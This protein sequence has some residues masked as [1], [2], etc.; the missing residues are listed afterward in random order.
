MKIYIICLGILIVIYNLCISKRSVHM[1]QQNMYNENNRY[2]K[3]VFKNL[4]ETFR[5]DILAL[6]FVV[7]VLDYLIE[8]WKNS[9]KNKS[10]IVLIVLVYPFSLSSTY[11]HLHFN[12]TILIL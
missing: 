5:F 6:I 12:Y 3:W 2:F 9:H 10:Y 1:L 4:K 7:L 11:N 8:N